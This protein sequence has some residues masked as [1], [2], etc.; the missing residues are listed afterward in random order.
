MGS[1][2]S[3]RAAGPGVSIVVGRLT[4]DDLNCYP[5]GYEVPDEV[6]IDEPPLILNP[7]DPHDNVA[8][9]VKHWEQLA[10]KANAM[11][12]RLVGR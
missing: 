4:W 5:D 6:Q 9:N 3:A 7:T 12:R 11:L 10:E 1:R 2:G 8:K